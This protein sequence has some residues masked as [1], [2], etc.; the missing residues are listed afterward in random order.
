LGIVVVV[1]I[2]AC[3]YVKSRDSKSAPLKNPIELASPVDLSS[4]SLPF[5]ENLPQ[6][7]KAVADD[8]M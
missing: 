4:P 5:S 1:V 3:L 6:G 8:F 7:D 2:V